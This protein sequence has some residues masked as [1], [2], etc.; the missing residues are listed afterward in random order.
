MAP[1]DTEITVSKKYVRYL[2]ESGFPIIEAYLYG[3]Y[4]KGEPNMSSDIDVA[5][6]VSKTAPDNM[7]GRARMRI[8]A[9]DVDDRFEVVIF[10]EDRFQDWHPLVHQI[11]TTGIRIK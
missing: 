9:N 6:V 10:P 2:K 3:S 11:I 7:D 5:L 8:L 4:A 1:R